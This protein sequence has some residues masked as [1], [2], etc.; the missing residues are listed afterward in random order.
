MIQ[1]EAFTDNSSD[2]PVRGF[3]HL[4]TNGIGDGLVFTHGAGGNSRNPLLVTLAE[5]LSE[6]GFIVLRCDL[7]FRQSRPNG[8]PRPG[9]A[10]RD[11]LGLKNAVAAMRKLAHGR[12]FLGGQSYGGRQATILCAEENSLVDGL[13]LTSYPLHPPGKPSQMRTQHFPQLHVRAL[14]AQGTRD[15]FA[16][17][18]EITAALKLIPAPVDLLPVEGLG[19]DLGSKGATIV[20]NWARQYWTAAG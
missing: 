16:T 4:P 9:D 8:P 17:I 14:F 10:P 5:K 18:Q 6:A 7:P 1:Y 15:P 2:P 19:H 20:A 13:L 12:V 3:L 11:R